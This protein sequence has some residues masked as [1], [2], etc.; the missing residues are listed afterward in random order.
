MLPTPLPPS[1][2]SAPAVSGAG[3]APT[4]P[5]PSSPQRPGAGSPH[6]GN[7]NA[8][9][10]TGLLVGPDASLECCSDEAP[11]R[12]LLAG[13]VPVFTDVDAVL[14]GPNGARARGT[15]G[16]TTYALRFSHPGAL[17]LAMRHL[18]AAYFSVPVATIR[19]IE[20]RGGG[21]SS[22]PPML[23][24]TC[25]DVRVLQLLFRDDAT[26]EK[27]ASHLRMVAFPAKADY[28]HAFSVAGSGASKKEKAAAAAAAS[29]AAAAGGDAVPLPPAMPVP[30]PGWDVFSPLRELE[31]L[32]VLR[33]RHPVTG[34]A[35]FRVSDINKDFSYSPTYPS[36]LAFP[37]R[38]TDAHM[39]I[40]AGFR[41]KARVPAITWMHPGNK[42]TL[43]R[44][45][46]PRVGLGGK[47]CAQDEQLVAWLR[48][49]NLFSR[50]GPRTPL[51]VADCRP[52]A[53][54][55]AN[56][57]AGGGYEQY[58]GTVLE[59]WCV[60][61][62]VGWGASSNPQPLALSNPLTPPPHFTATSTISMPCATPTANSRRLH[63]T[64]LPRT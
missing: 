26:A 3:A 58:S 25:K 49:A 6:G 61:G 41:S 8:W 34:E 10:S 9:H 19:K 7:P 54:A 24:L 47:S 51:L 60:L 37:S 13:E 39:A 55:M 23:E 43:S 29:A 31:R 30:Q 52:R 17:P 28:L 2:R 64:T 14:C 4:Q 44:C 16:A 32:G 15:L 45:S 57:L 42:T 18:P 62:G 1:S 53:N 50:E 27:M 46:Q 20:T 48:E 36:V 12:P 5:V 33:Q 63:S 59:F 22:L 38:A 21:S 40:V 56:N 11:G 35:L